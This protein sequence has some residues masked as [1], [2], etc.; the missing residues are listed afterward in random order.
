M[1][2]VTFRDY[3]M[4]VMQNQVPTAVG[5]L[6]TLLGLDESHAQTATTF[7]KERVTDPSFMPKAMGLRQAVTSGSDDEIGKLLVECFGLDPTQ[8]ASAVA[9]MRQHY[10]RPQ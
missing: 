8:R 6:Q 3:A 5:H 10:P 7:F 9:T 4:A 2:D 1:P